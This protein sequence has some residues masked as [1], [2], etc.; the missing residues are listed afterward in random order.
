MGVLDRWL[1]RLG[2]VRLEAHGLTMRWDGQ[3]VP[4]APEPPLEGVPLPVVDGLGSGPVGPGEPDDDE[5]WEWQLAIARA[6]ATVPPPRGPSPPAPP[7]LPPPP[8]DDDV[9][10]PRL[11]IPDSPRRRR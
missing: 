7:P 1:R 3:V 2:Y 8:G 4:L 9:T 6:R 11:R 10:L 5:E